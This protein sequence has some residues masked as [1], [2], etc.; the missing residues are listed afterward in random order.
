MAW[1]E[2]FRSIPD[3]VLHPLAIEN[4]GNL[5]CQSG[6]QIPV[7]GKDRPVQLAIGKP[8]IDPSGRGTR[9]LHQS[10]GL[11]KPRAVGVTR[12]VG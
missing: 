7:P 5:A 11:I 9:P 4:I 10:G 3:D 6:E 1:V 2:A 8:A 12:A